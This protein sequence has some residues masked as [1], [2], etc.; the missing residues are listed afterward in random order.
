VPKGDEVPLFQE[1]T[2]VVLKGKVLIEL[3]TLNNDLGQRIG[4]DHSQN[5]DRQKE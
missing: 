2:D 4:H 5:Q 1:S 3:E